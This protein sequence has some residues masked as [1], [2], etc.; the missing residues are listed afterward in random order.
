ML[1]LAAVWVPL[2]TSIRT[3]SDVARLPLELEGFDVPVAVLIEIVHN[4]RLFFLLEAGRPRSFANRRLGVAGPERTSGLP[5][6]LAGW[7]VGGGHQ[8]SLAVIRR[9]PRRS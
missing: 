1:L 2:R 7:S 4:P 8:G 5:I 9:I 3:S 6:G